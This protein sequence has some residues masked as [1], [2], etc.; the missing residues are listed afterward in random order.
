[1]VGAESEWKITRCVPAIFFVTDDRMSG[2]GKLYADL[3]MAAG[4]KMNPD[5]G[6]RKGGESRIF[7]CVQAF[8]GEP[9]LLRACGSFGNLFGSVGAAI[10]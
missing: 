5:E 6:E 9:G 3:V 1:M 8:V 7:Q 10:L 2:V 4:E